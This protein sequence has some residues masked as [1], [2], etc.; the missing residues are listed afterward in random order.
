MGEQARSQ[1]VNIQAEDTPALDGLVEV[2]KHRSLLWVLVMRQ[3]SVRYAQTFFGLFWILIQPGLTALLYWLV[4]GIFVKVPTGNTPYPLFALTGLSLWNLFA[5]GFDRAGA[6]IVQD[7]KLVTKVYFPRLLLPLA[8]SGS[9]LA[10]FAVA[11]AILL[12]LSLVF[13][14]PARDSSL[15]LLPVVVAVPYLLASGFGSI[16]GAVNIRFRDLRQVAPFLIQMWVWATPVAYPLEV[17]PP[18]WLPLLLAN[19]V[20]APV[21]VFRHILTGSSLPPVWSIWYSVVASVFVFFA[22]AWIFRKV[23]KDFADYI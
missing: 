15:L 5:Q 13:G 21:L 1:E 17:V 14:A 8:A 10:D 23:E 6:S 3:I 22:G 7:E 16:V 9:V 19:P 2:W 20:S 4:F 18:A 12:P 11:F